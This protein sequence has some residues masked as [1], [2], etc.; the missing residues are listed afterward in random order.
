MAEQAS[1]LQGPPLGTPGAGV[2]PRAGAPQL[3]ADEAA[4]V[5]LQVSPG[6]DTMMDDI[7]G[8]APTVPSRV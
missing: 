7:L 1:R 8:G 4:R 3:F 2:P 6:Q 5:G